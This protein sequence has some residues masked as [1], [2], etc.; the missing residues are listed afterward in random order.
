ME[1]F[2][3][4]LLKT[5]VTKTELAAQLVE[6]MGLTQRESRELVD[7]FFDILSTELKRGKTVKLTNFG[8]FHIHKKNARPG[9]NLQT[10]QEVEV[11]ARRTVTFFT[12]PKLRQL[13]CQH[14]QGVSPANPIRDGRPVPN[15]A[16]S[17]TV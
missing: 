4:D 5:S 1:L 8:T 6:H 16:S 3:D 15:A 11:P 13:M 2:I 12:G 9:R 7:G 10:S 17:H 14:D